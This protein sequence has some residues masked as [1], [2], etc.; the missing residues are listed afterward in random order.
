MPT[1][2]TPGDGYS[3]DPIVKADPNIV[4]DGVIQV[5][6]EH[7]VTVRNRDGQPAIDNRLLQEQVFEVMVT[8]EATSE[9]DLSANAII[10]QKLFRTILPN[11][12][13]VSMNDTLEDRE[14]RK[15]LTARLWG[16]C[17]PD[18]VSYVQKHLAHRKRKLVLCEAHIE[19]AMA[20]LD[21]PL[22]PLPIGRFVTANEEL[23]V[24]Y[25]FAPRAKKAIRAAVNLNLGNDLVISRLPQMR[26][27]LA[28]E[29]ADVIGQVTGA[30]P[31]GDVKAAK[32]LTSQRAAEARERQDDEVA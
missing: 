9:D 22:T 16:F 31:S 28:I 8:K 32:A 25:F 7:G 18:D 1:P 5:L 17:K 13:R 15:E 2:V 23:I 27:R 26:T 21:E 3:F 4:R 19:V 30:L 24:T 11:A 14:I 6:L 10:P 12:P 20:D 29:T